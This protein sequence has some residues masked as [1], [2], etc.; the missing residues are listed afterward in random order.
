MQSLSI[1]ERAAAYIENAFSCF[2]AKKPAAA[3]DWCM[4]GLALIDF[5]NEDA[6]FRDCS[7]LKTCKGMLEIISKGLSTSGQ[8]QIKIQEDLS[9]EKESSPAL[10]IP[11]GIMIRAADIHFSDII[12]CDLAKQA[13][14]ENVVLPLTLPSAIKTGLFQGN[15]DYLVVTAYLNYYWLLGTGI[16]KGSGN[17][18]LHVG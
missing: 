4:K 3:R 17:V 14:H 18:L 5:L 2:G 1:L 8:Q 11:P 16:R 6:A 15:V 7:S 10:T 9:I 12:G 13:L